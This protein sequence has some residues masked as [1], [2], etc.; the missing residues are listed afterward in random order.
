MQIERKTLTGI[1]AILIGCTSPIRNLEKQNKDK[2][3]LHVT[4]FHYHGGKNITRH[5]AYLWQI[6]FKISKLQAEL[7]I[8]H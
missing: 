6:T 5:F 2:F 3:N 8:I 1:A 4:A 7:C